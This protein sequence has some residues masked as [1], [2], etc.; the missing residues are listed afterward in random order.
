MHEVSPTVVVEREGA[1]RP[2]LDAEK[3]AMLNQLSRDRRE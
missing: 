2:L 1:A 3:V